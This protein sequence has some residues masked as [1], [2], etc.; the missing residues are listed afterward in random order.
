MRKF[1]KDDLSEKKTVG[2]IMDYDGITIEW[3]RGKQ[4]ILT[5]F[6]DGKEV[7]Q[8]KLY[9]L[10]T[11]EEMHTLMIKEGF[12]KKNEED[13]IKEIQA[14]RIEDQLRQVSGSSEIFNNTITGIYFVVIVVLAGIVFVL[15]KKKKPRSL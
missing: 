13:K 1:L 3:K 2:E 12:H 7:K 8:I 6:E 11:R 14:Q 15:R 9:E 5:I 10:K 4:A